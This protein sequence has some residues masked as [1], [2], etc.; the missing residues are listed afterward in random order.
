MKIYILNTKFVYPGEPYLFVIVVQ[1]TLKIYIFFSLSSPVALF[2]NLSPPPLFFLSVISKLLSFF[3]SLYRFGSLS[4]LGVYCICLYSGRRGC[5]FESFRY[6]L[7]ISSFP[8]FRLLFL[9]LY[10]LLAALYSLILFSF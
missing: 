5:Q 4:S 1:L 3:L 2:L 9:F 8:F 10:F 7:E 6:N